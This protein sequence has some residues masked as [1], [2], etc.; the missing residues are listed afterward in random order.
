M[1]SVVLEE[2]RKKTVILILVIIMLSA[3]AAAVVFPVF[4][5]LGWYPTVPV[6]MVAVL[7]IV[8]VIEDIIGCILM[9]RSLAYETLTNQFENWVKRYLLSMIVVNLNLII[10]IFPS[11]ESWMFA[12]YF[13]IPMAFF[14]DMKYIIMCSCMEGISLLVLFLFNEVT[15]PEPSLFW[16]EVMLRA[17]C[18]TL[19]FVGI[20]IFV[21]FMNRYLLNARKEEVERNNEKVTKVLV[22]V[23]SLSE[24]L[25][26][27]GTVLSEIAQNESASVQEL[28]ATSE[29]LLENSNLLGSKTEE[30]ITNL[31]ELSQWEGVLSGNVEKVESTSKDLLTTS[32]ENEVVLNELQAINSDVSKSMLST[33][34]VAQRL[35]QA[36]EEIGVTLKL[37]NDIS[38]STNL[39]ALNASIEA[40]RAGEAGRGFA[41]VAQEVGNLAGNTKESLQEVETVIVRVQENVSEITRHVEE[42]SQKLEKQN[43]YFN[44]V[45][46]GMQNMTN[47]LNVSVDAVNTM[48]EAHKS[49]ASVIRNTVV[50]NKDIAEGVQNENRQFSGINAMVES[51]VKDIAEMAEQVN[52]INGMVDEMVNLLKG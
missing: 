39:L 44:S 24:N 12:F 47:L 25:S 8:I 13:L 27:A 38:S 10:W 1:G 31:N 17:I 29:E 14:L 21:T 48:G 46:K 22:S 9:K 42:N 18:V 2:Y 41:V 23:Q 5:V 15:R 6:G 50:I 26:A 37:I 7:D 43:G 34:D 36:V 3:T 11:K 35:S 51:N 52:L 45:F 16:S 20:I 28:S 30:S 4:K 32:K 40:A 33:I 19:S 49:Q